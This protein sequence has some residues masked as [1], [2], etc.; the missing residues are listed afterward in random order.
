MIEFALHPNWIRFYAISMP[1]IVLIVWTFVRA[2]KPQPYVALLLSAIVAIFA[3]RQVRSVYVNQPIRVHL[4]AGEVATTPALYEML[5][6]LMLHTKPGEFFFRAKWPGLYVPLH[7]RNPLY[8]D[9][10]VPRDETRPEDVE[11]AIQQLEAN[12]VQYVLWAA[13]FDRHP[14]PH[15]HLAP[16]RNYLRTRYTPVQVFSDGDTIWQRNDSTGRP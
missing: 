8:V 7:L 12:R 4:P 2:A 15:D 11:S 9:E 14:F 13:E 1:A 16:L 5:H 10:V 3:L 6:W